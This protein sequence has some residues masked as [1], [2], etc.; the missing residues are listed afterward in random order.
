MTGLMADL[1]NLVPIEP[2][3]V[4][5]Q[6]WDRESL[7]VNWLNELLFLAE[8]ERL[9]FVDYQIESLTDTALVV[10]VRG[11]HSPV[12]KAAIK[13][14]TFHDLQLVH[15]GAGWSTVITFDV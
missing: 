13:A 5:L 12:T 4:R 3:E 6:G 8:T 9:L 7:L 1:D 11:A 10:R 2:R 14:A 15:D